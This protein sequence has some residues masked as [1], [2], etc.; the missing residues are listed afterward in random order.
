MKNP[1]L[2]EL[3]ARSTWSIFKLI[4]VPLKGEK[5][6]NKQTSTASPKDEH[7]YLIYSLIGNDEMHCILGGMV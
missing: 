7:A 1:S 4:L 5:Q 6:T 3:F 2:R